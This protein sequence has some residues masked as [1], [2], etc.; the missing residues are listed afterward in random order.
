M[1]RPWLSILG[2]LLGAALVALGTFALIAYGN[3][4]S[5]DFKTGRL[6]HKG[7]LIVS[8][9]PSS[10]KIYINGKA[11]KGGTPYRNTYDGGQYKL[12]VIKDG[13]RTWQKNVDVTP[14]QATQVQYVILLPQHLQVEAA[15]SFP[16]ISQT[17]ASIDHNRNALVVPS[18]AQ[19]GVWWVD[20]QSKQQ[21]R[22]YQ[23]TLDAAGQPS[24]KLE[25]LGWSNDASHLL[26]RRTGSDGKINL[27]VVA[28]NGN[29][30]TINLTDSLKQPFSE[31]R[32]SNNNWKQLYWSSPEG[33]R[34]IDI[35][36]QTVSQPL[37]DPVLAYTYAGD[38]IVYIANVGVNPSLWLLESGGKRSRL[39]DKLPISKNYQIDYATYINVPQVVVTASDANQAL[40]Y[41][42]VFDHPKLKTIPVTAGQVR[43]N[44][45]GRF[46]LLYDDMHVSTYDLERERL[47][48]FPEINAAVTGISWFDNYHLLFNR[49]GQIVLSEYDGNYAIA[50]TRG[51]LNTPTGSADNKRIFATAVTSNGQSQLKSIKIRN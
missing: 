7:L 45:D 48:S 17:L 44:G 3:G 12:E 23:T 6:A 25:I 19:A 40:L 32:F 13:Y 49:G 1:K 18:S 38:R 35:G 15:A 5:Y 30:A 8:S 39:A 14:A 43:F 46:A 26:L 34:K 27:L 16:A 31:L 10:A 24:E 42:N 51:D 36:S 33:L 50:V 20:T 11:G 9:I 41:S 4:Y 28:A 21:T 22:V 29:D 2:F 47:Y 37:T